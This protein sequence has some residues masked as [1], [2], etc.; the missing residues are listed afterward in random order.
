SAGLA[1]Q[2]STVES[3]ANF[4]P[5]SRQNRPQRL[6]APLDTAYLRSSKGTQVEDHARLRRNDVAAGAAFDDAGSDRGVTVNAVPLTN[7]SELPDD[8]VNRIDALVRSEASVRGA[9]VR[10]D[11]NFANAFASGLEQA[12]APEGRLEDEDGVAAARFGL[13]DGACG[14]AAD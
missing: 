1:L 10:N 9:S 8:L 13:D 3:A 6:Q 11:F 2:R 12:V 14:F 4:E 7:A 5:C